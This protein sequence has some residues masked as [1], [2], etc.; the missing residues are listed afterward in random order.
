MGSGMRD[1]PVPMGP[2][3]GL[4]AAGGG[5]VGG[6]MA[7]FPSGAGKGGE[8]AVAP[9]CQEYRPRVFL[10]GK[11]PFAPSMGVFPPKVPSRVSWLRVR[12]LAETPQ[13]Q[14]T[15]SSKAP[16][17]PHHG[18][19]GTAST[20]TPPLCPPPAQGQVREPPALLLP[21]PLPA[22]S[23]APGEAGGQKWGQGRGTVPGGGALRAAGVGAARLRAAPAAPPSR[24]A[25]QRVLCAQHG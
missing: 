22:A 10:A 21:P 2:G 20:G 7:P 8:G 4:P 6:G 23:A 13:T 25:L 14:L 3:M 9:P 15:P 16:R 18:S 17:A 24:L 5:G 1:P 12:G 19:T 11:V